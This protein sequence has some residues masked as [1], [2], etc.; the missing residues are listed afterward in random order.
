M[1]IE[2]PMLNIPK[3]HRCFRWC[4]CL[5]YAMFIQFVSDAKENNWFPR[6]SC[7][8]NTCPIELPS[9]GGFQYLGR[10]WTFDDLEESTTISAKVRHNHVH[11]FIALG[12]N[13]L[14]PMHI[15]TPWTNEDCQTHMNE[16]GMAGLTRAIG[17]ADATHIAIEK[18]SHRLWNNHLGPKQHLTARTF[19]LT[20][21]HRWCIL[22]TT[23]GYPGKWN[24]KTVVLFD[25]F[26]CGIYK[27]LYIFMYELFL[28]ITVLLCTLTFLLF[29]AKGT[30]LPDLRL[31][32][33]SAIGKAPLCQRFITVH[34]L[35]LTTATWSGV[36]LLHLLSWWW[37]KQNAIGVIGAS[38][39]E[40]MWS[41]L[42][43]F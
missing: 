23:A 14:Y 39:Y 16:F 27:G 11:E 34:G 10:G 26:V 19:N 24:D 36:Q 15:L 6:W 35:L 8:N 7:W 4:F 38:P 20:V 17:S 37:M 33:L 42:L 9:L 3:L 21:N 29:V 5:L 2:H 43:G 30:V 31:N 13:V 25:S 41:A 18:C 40:K 28:C 1:H 32:L 22:S 12:A